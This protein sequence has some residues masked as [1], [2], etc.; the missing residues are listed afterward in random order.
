MTL[1]REQRLMKLGAAQQSAPAAWRLVHIVGSGFLLRPPASMQ[2]RPI[3]K[4]HIR[5][6]SQ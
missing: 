3:K 6:Q 5:I 4:R 2:S 1:T